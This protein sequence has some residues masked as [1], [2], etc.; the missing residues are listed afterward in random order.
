[1]M[2]IVTRPR[3]DADALAHKLE[4]LGHEVC[5]SPLLTI[6]AT[7]GARIP[8][9]GYQAVLIT[10]AN[11]A[12]ALANH[13]ARSR[14]VALPA[15]TVGSQSAEVARQAGFA[16]VHQTGGNVAALTRHVVGALSPRDG[17]LLYLSGE[18]TSGDLVGGLGA[19][20]FTVDRVVLYGARPA[21]HLAPAAMA[22]IGSGRAGGVLLY[23]PRTA[24]LWV[25]CIAADNLVPYMGAL[26]HYCLSPQVAAALPGEWTAVTAEAAAEDVLLEKIGSAKGRM[27]VG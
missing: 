10:S 5:L 25:K 4:A 24:A 22:A 8:P 16:E 20:G 7:P 17:P 11:G 3:R 18:E 6:V 13:E 1:M 15:I 27:N 2:L 14:I 12:R 21:S 23:S 9:A 19:R 26:V